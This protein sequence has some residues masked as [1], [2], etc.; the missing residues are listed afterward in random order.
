MPVVSCFLEFLVAPPSQLNHMHT[1]EYMGHTR[2][3]TAVHKQIWGF[4]KK[5][6]AEAY[7]NLSESMHDIRTAI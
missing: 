5:L 3:F 4:S 2:M 1:T 7:Q 6:L